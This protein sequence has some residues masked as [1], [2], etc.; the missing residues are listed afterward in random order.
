MSA[1]GEARSSHPTA[2]PIGDR[3]NL[4]TGTAIPGSG[5]TSRS[6]LPVEADTSSSFTN[7]KVDHRPLQGQSIRQRE[8]GTTNVDQITTDPV[9]CLDPACRRAGPGKATHFRQDL[10]ATTDAVQATA[11]HQHPAA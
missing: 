3:R 10:R 8:K 4:S 7:K 1:R 2:A 6:G 5:S 11:V 9:G